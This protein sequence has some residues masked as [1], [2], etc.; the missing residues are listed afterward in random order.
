MMPSR[1]RFLVSLEAVLKSIVLLEN[2]LRLVGATS[3]TKIS[4]SIVIASTLCTQGRDSLGLTTKLDFGT[5]AS[6]VQDCIQMGSGRPLL[7]S[8]GPSGST[9]RLNNNLCHF[10]IQDVHFAQDFLA[11]GRRNGPNEN[12]LI[13]TI[14]PSARKG[15]IL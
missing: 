12:S 14:A 3:P 5:A 11:F 10:E 8:L 2:S 1:W 15:E 13:P 9:A 7:A 6:I 4:L